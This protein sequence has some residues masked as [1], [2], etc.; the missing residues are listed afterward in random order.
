MDDAE[1]TKQ[2][3]Q[4]V[5]LVA[6]QVARS[7]TNIAQWSLSIAIFLFGLLFSIIIM[8]SLEVDAIIVSV[9]A[10]LGLIIVW[11]I[12]W[13]RGRQMYQRFYVE[14][15]INLQQKP[16][17][18]DATLVRQLSQREIQILHYAA[19]GYANK[20]IANE[21]GISEN[22]VKYFVS[23]M[24]KKLNASD[25]TEAVVIAIKNGVIP[26]R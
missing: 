18:N 14:A 10:I 8:V 26:I 5:E 2:Y 16:G 12:G 20:R 13:N 25:R 9:L 17:V 3:S 22:T 11:Y 19:Q 4:E 7:K 6:M 15:L 23:N 24:L 21:L 1:E